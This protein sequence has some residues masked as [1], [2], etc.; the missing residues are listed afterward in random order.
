MISAD[1]IQIVNAAIYSICRRLVSVIKRRLA[2]Y[3]PLSLYICPVS[4]SVA[5]D[6][7]AIAAHASRAVLLALP[8]TRCQAG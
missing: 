4:K 3:T 6:V 2:P 8:R 5:F 7:R 1:L